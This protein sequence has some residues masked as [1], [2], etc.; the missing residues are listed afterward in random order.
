M[1]KIHVILLL[2]YLFSYDSYISFYGSGERLSK[3]NPSNISLGWSN[4]FD[5]NNYYNI[6]SLSSFYQSDLVRFSMASDF[7]LNFINNNNYYSQKL[8][9]FSFL[10][11]V[12]DNRQSFGISLSPFYRINATIIESEF[13]YI[14]GNEDNPPYAYKSEYDFEGGPSLVSM[15]LS[16]LVFQNKSLRISWGLKFNYIFGSLYSYIQNKTYNIIYDEEGEMETSLNS[17]DYYTNINSYNGYGFEIECSINNKNQKII[18]SFNLIDNIEINQSFYDDIV[19]ESLEL[20]I[21][22]NEQNSYKISSPFEFNIGYFY[23]LNNKHSFI[24]EYYSY[25]PYESN[26]NLFDNSDVNK[27]RLSI[28]YYK[29]LFNQKISLSTGVYSINSYNDFLSSNRSGFTFGLGLH[30]IKYMSI[31]FCLEFGQ[32]EIEISVPLSEKYVNLYIGLTGSDKWF[33]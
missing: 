15:M 10:L 23:N 32:N 5:S 6:G 19:P 33:K 9:Y 21:S 27:N 1:K 11:P 13:N 17:T 3:L 14:E 4:L 31:D 22:P 16:S 30:S 8:N 18:G 2:S 12:R 24:I 7:N 26:I 29:S 28:G 20:G 25:S